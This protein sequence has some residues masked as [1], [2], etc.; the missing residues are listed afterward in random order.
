MPES[1]FIHEIIKPT[2]PLSVWIY[3]HDERD[4]TYIA[5]HW[6][7]AI[8]LSYTVFGTIDDFVINQKHFKTN[9]GKVLVINSQEVHS[10]YARSNN[11]QAISI[12]FP[13]PLVSRLY[14]R[15][16]DQFIDI[17]NTEKFD[18]I[19][20]EAY[21]KLQTNLFKMYQIMKS[22]D[23]YKNLKLE[24]ASIE[25]LQLLIEYFT[26]S[27]SEY[28]KMYGTKEFVVNRIQM[29]TKF[30]NENYYRKI[31]LDDIAAD[32][33]VSKEYLTKFF[34][35]YM[36]LTVGQYIT[37]VRA[38]KAYYDILGK[39]GNLTQIANKNGFS[40]TRAMNKAFVGIYGKNA[41]VIYKED[42]N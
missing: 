9:C 29:I 38:Q 10:V 36:D 37:N 15:I 31:S 26:E 1:S 34:K 21:I 18:A 28:K 11:S 3:L 12:I 40:T 32:V 35:K 25:I 16:E 41:N 5:P 8:E 27:K 39:A 4:V 22:D 24:A 6:H 42:N 19:K 13:Y 20:K 33:N 23:D 17:N 2:N 7:Q 30:V 14:P